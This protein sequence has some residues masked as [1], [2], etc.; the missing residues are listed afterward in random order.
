MTIGISFM[1][2]SHGDFSKICA[3][4]IAMISVFF[5]N[6]MCMYH[7]ERLMRLLGRKSLDIVVRLLGMIVT[8]IAVELVVSGVRTTFFAGS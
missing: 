4:I 8:T 3:I 7:A 2:E 1:E 5:M 6:W